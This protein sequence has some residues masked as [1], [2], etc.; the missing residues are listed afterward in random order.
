MDSIIS[1]VVGG[2]AFATTSLKV[3]V[4]KAFICNSTYYNYR[5]AWSS[6]LDFKTVNS[7]ITFLCATSSVCSMY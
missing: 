6:G 3:S 5:Y 2:S 1:L 7:N 4:I